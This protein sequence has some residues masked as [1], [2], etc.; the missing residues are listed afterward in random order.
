MSHVLSSNTE[1]L[2]I[3]SP[4]VIKSVTITNETAG[5]LELS[6]YRYRDTSGKPFIKI[7]AAAD[8]TT[9]ILFDGLPFP[10]GFTIVPE[11]ALT[12]YIV[13]YEPIH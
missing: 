3:Q 4:V 10:D 12:F 11:A 13:E 5:G 8:V 1:T 7:A 6:I 9:Q 2:E